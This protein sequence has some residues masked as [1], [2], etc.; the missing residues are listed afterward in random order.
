MKSCFTLVAL[1]LC[2]LYVQGQGDS[3]ISRDDIDSGVP[4]RLTLVKNS[5]QIDQWHEDSFWAAY[6]GY[7]AKAEKAASAWDARLNTL[8]HMDAQTDPLVAF[9]GAERMIIDR[10]RQIDLWQQSFQEISASNNGTIGLKFLQTE[11]LLAMMDEADIYEA[12]AGPASRRPTLIKTPL[13][14]TARRDMMSEA[15]VIS[16]DKKAIFAETF[17]KYETERIDLLGDDYSV[18]DLYVGDLRDFTPAFSKRLGRD[19]IEVMRRE[20]K[21]KDKY[22]AE[23]A[24]AVGPAAAARFIA[25]EDYQSILCKMYLWSTADADLVADGSN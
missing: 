22:L 21:L 16:E 15:L 1:A 5:M 12:S 11:T 24:R 25:L 13:S 17:D 14:R 6:D 4:D 23:M 10:Y 18:Y 2:S 9:D 19:F 3:K 20:T 7:R 8:A